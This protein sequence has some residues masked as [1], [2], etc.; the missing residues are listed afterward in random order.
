[1]KKVYVRLVGVLS[2]IPVDKY[3][4]CVVTMIIASAF[5]HILP[6]GWLTRY[7]VSVLLTIAIGVLKEL[8]DKKDYGL[9]DRKDIYAD[10]AGAVLGALM[11]I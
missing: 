7:I 1:M 8:Y 3:I 9:F 4:H 11:A 6:F 5:M 10:V 2:A